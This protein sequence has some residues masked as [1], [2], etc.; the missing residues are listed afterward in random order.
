MASPDPDH[1]VIRGRTPFAG[2]ILGHP[3]FIGAA[4]YGVLFAALWWA[5]GAAVA[6]FAALVLLQFA[7]VVRVVAGLCSLLEKGFK[8][9]FDRR[10]IVVVTIASAAFFIVAFS[11][12][13]PASTLGKTGAV[14][15]VVSY[16]VGAYAG[17]TKLGSGGISRDSR[18]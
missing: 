9:T 13:L 10:E 4:G 11:A 7:L 18:V 17:R 12:D 14:V 1:A 8:G 3:I 15:G 16:F 5:E 6:T 2:P